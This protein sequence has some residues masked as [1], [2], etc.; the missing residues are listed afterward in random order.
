MDLS[1]RKLFVA[2]QDSHRRTLN[3]WRSAH[4]KIRPEIKRFLIESSQSAQHHQWPN[5]SQ[6]VR[7]NLIL[8]LLNLV[9]NL[10]AGATSLMGTWSQVG[11]TS[12][13]F[14][15]KSLVHLSRFPTRRLGWGE[16]PNDRDAGWKFSLSLEQNSFDDKQSLSLCMNFLGKSMKKEEFK[17]IIIN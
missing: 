11:R 10:A 12:W 9:S 1:K 6:G 5:S 16:L 3:R 17:H 15:R 4:D 7:C 2:E 14:C 8:L 13:S